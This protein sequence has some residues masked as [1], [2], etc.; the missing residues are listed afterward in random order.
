MWMFF[1][2]L[3]P[4]HCFK[5]SEPK[6]PAAP[7]GLLFFRH[8]PECL[9]RYGRTQSQS[10]LAVSYKALYHRRNMPSSDMLVGLTCKGVSG[11]GGLCL[12]SHNYMPGFRV[13]SVKI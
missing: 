6:E 3:H 10:L 7:H 9:N 4:R 8:I 5:N 11:L 1:D 13:I 12:V 2:P